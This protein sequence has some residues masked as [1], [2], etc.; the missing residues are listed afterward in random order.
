MSMYLLILLMF[1]FWFVFSVHPGS[2]LGFALTAAD[3]GQLWRDLGDKEKQTKAALRS[4]GARSLAVQSLLTFFGVLS[5][6]AY[7]PHDKLH[8]LTLMIAALGGL[9]AGYLVLIWMT[10]DKGWYGQS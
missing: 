3:W 4:A 7:G 9:A 1:G 5:N 6:Y 8:T 2:R 10:R